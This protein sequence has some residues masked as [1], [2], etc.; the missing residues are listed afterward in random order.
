MSQNGFVTVANIKD[1]QVGEIKFVEANGVPITL[2]NVE[3]Q[4]FAI[5][6]VCTHDEGPL[7]GGLLD[8]YAIECPRHGARFD[9]R[10]GKVLCLPAAMPIPTYEVKVEGDQIQVRVR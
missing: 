1:I 5:G 6:N 7:S 4:I 3:G 10:S 2:C 9:V 8:G